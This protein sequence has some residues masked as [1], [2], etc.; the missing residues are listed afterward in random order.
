MHSNSRNIISNQMHV[1][2][3]LLEI[4]QKHLE[5]PYRKPLA[6][7]SESAFMN[8]EKI[9]HGAGKPLILDSGC[10][11]GESTWN[12]AQMYPDH[13]VLGI[14]KSAHRLSKAESLLEDSDRNFAFVRADLFDFWPMAVGAGWQIDRHYLLYPNPW[15]KKKHLM[16]RYHAHP[17]FSTLLRMGTY[18]EL[19]SNWLI[20]LQ[21]FRLAVRHVLNI[22][23]EI[24]P[25][26]PEIY[27]TN[28]EKKYHI[29]GQSLYKICF[30]LNKD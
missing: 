8:A 30:S 23:A 20:Y 15:P 5:K 27:L 17:E 4:V 9:I 7:Y 3:K 24:T 25:I 22:D 10:G 18:F 29:S 13:F 14:D 6:R 12:L 26:E 1:H 2:E 11:T 28:F 16:R 21:E 19:R